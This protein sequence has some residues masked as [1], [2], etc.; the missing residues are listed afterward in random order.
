YFGA[1]MRRGGGTGSLKDLLAIHDDFD[2][3][4]AFLGEHRSHRIEVG[5]GLPPKA[6]TNFHGNDFDLGFG[7]TENGRR[8][9]PNR[10]GPLG[11]RPDRN[12][13]TGRPGHGA[14]VGFDVAMMDRLCGDL[15]FDDDISLA[16]SRLHV[17]QLVLDMAGNV[18][19][20]T[21]VIPTGEP[22]NP[23][24]CGHLLM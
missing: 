3:T 9:R 20:D 16:E 19:L 8:G 1:H 11:T 15:P 18:A 2:R 23:E 14:D 7:Q 22:F 24:P 4:T 10:K 6:T 17:P 5:H 21:R 13:V 12:G